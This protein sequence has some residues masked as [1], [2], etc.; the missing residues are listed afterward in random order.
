[1]ADRRPGRGQDAP[2]TIDRLTQI[3]QDERESFNTKTRALK[4]KLEE[5][6]REAERRE[7]EIT[8]LKRIKRET[9]QEQ[10]QM[11]RDKVKR[12]SV[13]DHGFETCQNDLR[14]ATQH[15]QVLQHQCQTH[16][17]TIQQLQIKVEEKRQNYHK[18]MEKHEAL[19][20]EVMEL[21]YEK[22]MKIQPLMDQLDKKDE[23]IKQLKMQLEHSGYD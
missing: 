2:G 11:L 15:I 10:E 1:M 19:R 16:Q 17:E 21:L 22:E 7:W 4:D 12:I 20:V 9:D 8:E 18:L 5:R 13:L 3:L 14:Q 6:V 23:T